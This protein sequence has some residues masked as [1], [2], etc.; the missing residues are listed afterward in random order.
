MI[1]AVAQTRP[2]LVYRLQERPRDPKY[3]IWRW[4]ALPNRCP[5]GKIGAFFAPAAYRKS[6]Q[7]EKPL[8]AYFPNCRA[9]QDAAE[10]IS[11]FDRIP[12]H[13]GKAGIFAN[14]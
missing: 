11:S 7:R 9:S 1:R 4:A 10:P 6:I 12:Q 3:H 14:L 2:M 13:H 5:Q 8:S